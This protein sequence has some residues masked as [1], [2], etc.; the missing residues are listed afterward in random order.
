MAENQRKQQ[1]IMS[2][3]QVAR[4]IKNY[5]DKLTAIIQSLC[6]QIAIKKFDFS[7]FSGF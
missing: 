4:E 6:Y 7:Y 2:V 5:L 1:D 3:L